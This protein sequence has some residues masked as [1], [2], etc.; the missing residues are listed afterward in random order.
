MPTDPFTPP[1]EPGPPPPAPASL[2]AAASVP[3]PADSLTRFLAFLVDAVVVGVVSSVP[4]VGGL[5]GTI[6]VLLRDGLD[7]EFMR[8]RSLGKRV[9]GL[10]VLRDDGRAMDAAASF[11]RNWPLAFGSLSVLLLFIPVLGWLL[12]P[13]VLLAGLVFAI[14]EVVRVLTAEDGRRWGDALAG[15]RVVREEPA[16]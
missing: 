7:V 16:P 9:M 2:D 11:R 13:F 1:P 14:V 6:Y 5:A 10:R 8:H 4:L 3:A 15:T 12:I